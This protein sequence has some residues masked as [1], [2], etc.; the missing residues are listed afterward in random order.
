[1]TYAEAI[2]KVGVTREAVVE[3]QGADARQ[4]PVNQINTNQTF[5]AFMVD[6]IWAARS[7]VNRSDLIK[8]VTNAAERFLENVQVDPA[9]L[10][11]FMRLKVETHDKG[12]KGRQIK[13][14]NNYLLGHALR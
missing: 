8:I 7:G 11:Q 4:K 5:V 3:V 9:E 6:V 14:K 12:K 13:V 1:M 10:H 2:K